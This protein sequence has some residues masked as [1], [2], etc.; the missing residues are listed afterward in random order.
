MDGWDAGHTVVFR[1]LSVINLPIA[2][3]GSTGKSKIG[4]ISGTTRDSLPCPVM[5]VHPKDCFVQHQTKSWLVVYF[6]F[7]TSL[8]T[9]KHLPAFNRR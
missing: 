6:F 8:V 3:I 5:R 1:D 2:R 7:R 4:K 9:P